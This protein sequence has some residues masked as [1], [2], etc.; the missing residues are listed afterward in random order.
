MFIHEFWIIKTKSYVESRKFKKDTSGIVTRV[1]INYPIAYINSVSF[2]VKNKMVAACFWN[3]KKNSSALPS[4]FALGSD[5]KS[6]CFIFHATDEIHNSE[7]EIT[8]T[9]ER[10]NDFIVSLPYHHLINY[11]L[12]S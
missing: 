1:A 11:R 8:G 3:E 10:G 7:I 4:S 5:S 12:A 9:D 2:I 6:G